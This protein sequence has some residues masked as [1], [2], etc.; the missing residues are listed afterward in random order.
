MLTR[1][2]KE[3]LPGLSE[4]ERE[5]LLRIGRSDSEPASHVARAK[6]LLA[7]AAGKT[8]TEAAGWTISAN[9][10]LIC[11]SEGALIARLVRSR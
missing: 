2:R 7:V 9:R 8:Y 11:A 10:S 4:A 6:G 3:S 5:M 1:H